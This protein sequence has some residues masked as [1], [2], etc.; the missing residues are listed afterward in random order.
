MKT[1]FY[2]KL[3]Y[4]CEELTFTLLRYYENQLV[5]KDVPRFYDF[6]PMNSIYEFDGE[7]FGKRLD[8]TGTMKWRVAKLHHC[9]PRKFHPNFVVK[10]LHKSIQMGWFDPMAIWIYGGFFDKTMWHFFMLIHK[11]CIKILFFFHKW[12]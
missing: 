11:E 3:F 10:L 6:C 7:T 12:M 5:Y 9:T 8:G 1:K 4:D 2:S